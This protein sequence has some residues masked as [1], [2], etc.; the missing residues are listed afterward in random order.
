[1]STADRNNRSR[2]RR[3]F[4]LLLPLGLVGIAVSTMAAAAFRFL[5]PVLSAASDRWFDVGQLSEFTGTNPVPRK[6]N[7]EHTAGW[8]TAVE[9]HNVFVLPAKGN[10]VV[11][12]ICPHEGCEVYWEPT[13]SVFACPCH[14]SSFAAN[15]SRLKGPAL[16]GLDPLASRVVDGKLQVQYQL[17]E[18]NTPERITRS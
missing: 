8:A 15:G 10:E 14:E 17:F 16:R 4:L 11:S 12:A 2:S 5:R 3:T 13:Q 6:V 1:M 18:N 7:A 9:A